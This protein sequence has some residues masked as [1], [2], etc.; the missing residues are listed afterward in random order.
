MQKKKKINEQDKF[1]EIVLIMKKERKKY[2]IFFSIGFVV[3]ILI[4]YLMVNFNEVYRGG[5]LDLIGGFFWTFIFLQI[6]PFIYC[7]IFAWIRY[8]GIKNKNE[9]M[10]Y[11]S[12]IIFF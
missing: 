12:Q 3:M 8:Y 1:N 6:I 5:I 9:K 4:F 7:L 2:I 10:F 11:Y